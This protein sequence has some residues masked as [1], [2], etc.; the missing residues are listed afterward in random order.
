[1]QSSGQALNAELGLIPVGL[2]RKESVANASERAS[3]L[4]GQAIQRSDY[5]RSKLSQPVLAYAERNLLDKVDMQFSAEFML[6]SFE[7]LGIIES[8]HLGLNRLF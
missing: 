3:D 8:C 7:E 6:G 1:V 4:E 5:K 2:C